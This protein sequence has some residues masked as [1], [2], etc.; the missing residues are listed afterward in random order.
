MRLWE[1]L[2]SNHQIIDNVVTNWEKLLNNSR[3]NEENYH[4]Y[5]ATYAGLFF[6]NSSTCLTSISKLNLGDDYQTDFILLH[7]DGSYGFTYELIEIESPHDQIFT[8]KGL[9]SNKLIQAI[10]QISDWRDWLQLNR[11]QTCKLF[12]SGRQYL[13]GIAKFQHTIYIG[14]RD[15]LVKQQNLRQR[16]ELAHKLAIRS[17]DALTDRLRQ[18]F[19]TN[20]SNLGSAEERRLSDIE[21][22]SLVNPFHKAYTGKQW[23]LISASPYFD[24]SHSYVSNVQL[25]LKHRTYNELNDKYSE[26]CFNC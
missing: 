21:R 20:L 19:F 9:P 16:E 24:S 17:F 13:Q 5:L 2:N 10:K 11:H 12:P 23:K 22:N 4:K 1:K 18:R 26:I 6:A 7:D 8:A 25:L 3:Q 15:E 14:R